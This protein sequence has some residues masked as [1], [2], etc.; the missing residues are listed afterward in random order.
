MNSKPT[1][2]VCSI[3]AGLRLIAFVLVGAL[4]AACGQPS[5]EKLMASAKANLAKGERSTALIELKNVLQENPDNGE[6]RFLL[7]KASLEQRDFA[8]AQKE[9]RRALELNQ[10]ADQVLPLLAQA[11]TELGQQEGLIKEFGERKLDAPLAQAS[12]QSIL[13]DAYLSRNEPAAAAAAYA[14]ALQAQPDFTPAQ[15]GQATLLAREGKYDESLARVDA[16]LAA[17]PKSAKAHSLRSSLLL[18][19]NDP[20]GARKALEAAIEA[21]P[22]YLP[23]RVALIS[24][25]THE[26]DFEAAGK[27][28]ESTRK[29][30]PRDL[31]VN[32]LDASLA[33]RKGEL[34]RA[35]QQLQQVLKVV[36]NHLPSIVLLGA[37]DLREK[38]FTEAEANLR[39]A[40][41][42][43]PNLVA[44]RLLLVQAY[45][46]MGQP[47]KARDA[48]QPVLAGG[49]PQDP[50]VQML[51]GET[52][53]ANGEVQRAAEFYQAASKADKGDQAVARTRLGQ[54]ALA[55]GKSDQGFRELEAASELDAGQ[56][57]A[58]LALITGYLRRNEVDKAMEAVKAL[59]KKQPNNPLTFQL[60]GVVNL[61]R[62]DTAAARRSF[63]KALELQPNYLPA[64]FNLAMLDLAEKRPEDARKRYEAMIAKDAKNDQLYLALADLQARTGAEPKAFGETLQRAV[65]ANPQSALAQLSLIEFHLRSKDAKAAVAA[66][67]SA[68]AALP[69]DPR[70]LEASAVALE[71]AGEVNQAIEAYNKVAALQPQSPQPLLRLAGLYVRQKNYNNAIEA[72]RRVQKLAPGDPGLLPQVVQLYLAAGR[73]ED[74]LGEVREVQ[75]RHPKLALAHAME[76]EIY[77]R[78]GSFADAERALREA[79]RLEPKADVVARRLHQVLVAG[80][81]TAEASAFASQWIAKNPKDLAMRVQVAEY[82]LSR[83]NLKPAAAHYKAV[84]E[85]DADN[86]VALNNLAW[87]G[88][89]LGDPKALSY[90][91][92]A[93]K[94]SPDNPSVID[95][96]GSLL[97]RQGEV[98]K[99]LAQIERARK[100]D[101]D[102]NALRLS[103]AK[104]LIKAGRK[105]A[106]RDELEALQAGQGS[107][108]G[109]DEI[110]A[111]LKG[112]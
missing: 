20:A 39:R 11:M 56:Y 52:F 61:A 7:G 55:T 57:Q 96:Y 18:V 49:M 36:P 12:F 16:I 70:I 53:L 1:A 3:A 21:D 32:Y 13:G 54:I 84:L 99:G 47:A 89:E 15:L 42:L 28:V 71:A 88:G 44:P 64:A 91:E 72:M 111:L 35:R 78:R 85:A 43:A 79:L 4:L 27:A 34:E 48:L 110:P 2:T 105:K 76:G 33:F 10:P 112:L 23:A 104:A 30:A 58:D 108:P 31:Q 65:N 37:I 97:V 66:A 75:R 101:P 6:A 77:A 50:K 9:L 67:Q 100:L 8:G 107:F 74:A 63:D 25:L 98:E 5:P 41:S 51:A 46:R 90:A 95:T 86:V 69:N 60:Y 103:Y 73:P 22:D 59:E 45:L 24:L 29:A 80:G 40:V 82:E 68:Q 17:T 106:A 14:A 26:R 94:L 81:K 102:S 62:K 83:R 87:I 109:S 92:R 38:K 93:V 19:R